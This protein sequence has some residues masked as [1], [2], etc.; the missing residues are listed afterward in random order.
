[1]VGF[2]F[3]WET[4]QLS[5]GNFWSLGDRDL[6]AWAVA[7]VAHIYHITHQQPS[8]GW[9]IIEGIRNWIFFCTDVY[10]KNVLFWSYKLCLHVL[11]ACLWVN[12]AVFVTCFLLLVLVTESFSRYKIQCTLSQCYPERAKYQ[13]NSMKSWFVPLFYG[14]AICVIQ[15]FISSECLS[16][17]SAD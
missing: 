17:F 7:L 9:S 5:T 15:Y 16:E 6:L 10:W 13:W 3:P 4:G 1:M 2:R 12:R 8:F 11:V 14:Q